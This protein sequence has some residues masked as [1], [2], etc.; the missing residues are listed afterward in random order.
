MF[1]WNPWL[2]AVK[3]SFEVQSVITMR[4][5]KIAAGGAGSAAESLRMVTEKVEA[6]VAGQ[7]AGAFAL[8]QG[9]G[10]KRAAK[11]A[12]APVK[13]RVRANHRRLKPK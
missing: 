10:I 3:F 1:Y 13:R 9:Q 8:A 6:A 7:T 4:V 11:R 5:L 12:I 2:E